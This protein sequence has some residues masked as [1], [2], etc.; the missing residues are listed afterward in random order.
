MPE[1]ELT[2]LLTLNRINGL[3]PTGAKFLYGQ[4]GSALEIFRSRDH[5][6]EIIPG[7]DSR[8][9]EALDGFGYDSFIREELEFIER[10]GIR[11]VTP[12]DPEYPARMLDLS[13]SPLVLFS[14]GNVNYNASRTVAVVGTRKATEYGRRMCHT[15]IKELQELC[16]DVTVVSG[17]AYGI[18]VESHKSSLECGIPTLGVLAHGLRTST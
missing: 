15:F 7:V 1:D 10:H 18:D 17:L 2:A 8:L 6:K 3:G 9:I 14:L 13:D 12:V 5:L 11:C 4:F 16:P